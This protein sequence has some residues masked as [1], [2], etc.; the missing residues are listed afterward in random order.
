MFEE[1]ENDGNEMVGSRWVIIR[2]EKADGRK[3]ITRGNWSPRESKKKKRHSLIHL[4][5]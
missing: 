5:C 3:Q 4:R 1:V 2:K